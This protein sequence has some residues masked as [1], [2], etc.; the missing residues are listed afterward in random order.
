MFSENDRNWMQY[1]IL[2]AKNAA[3][4]N[5]I[6]VGAVLLKNNQIIGEGFNQPINYSDPCAHAEIIALR[7]GARALCNYRLLDTTLYVT[8]EP[9]L[10][11]VGALVHARVARVVF[12]AHDKR[13]GAIESM[14]DINSL[15]GLN[16]KIS[17]QGGLLSD[18]CSKLLSDFF[19]ERRKKTHPS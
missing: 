5:E 15:S 18:D 19:S 16:H 13:S 17:Y 10:M 9:C 3:Q 8:L 6:P 2:L 4:M 11:C 7:N 12:G 14:L 1:A